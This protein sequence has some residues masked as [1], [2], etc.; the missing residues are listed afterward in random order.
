MQ[1]LEKMFKNLLGDKAL[2]FGITNYFGLVMINQ[3][4]NKYPYIKPSEEKQ[5]E[6]NNW[7]NEVKEKKK[8]K[9]LTKFNIDNTDKRNKY[10]SKT[11]QRLNASA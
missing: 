4:I 9:L 2:P 11:L 5:L 6:I 1:I 10:L 8:A 3:K 7:N